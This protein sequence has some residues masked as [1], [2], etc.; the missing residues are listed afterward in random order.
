MSDVVVLASG[1][2]ND[3]IDAGLFRK[4]SIHVFGFLDED[5]DGIQDDNEGRF[6][7]DPGKTFELLDENGD[8]D[9]RQHDH[10]WTARCG[11]TQLMPGTYTVRENP[12]PDGFTLTTL[13]NQRTF[14]VISGVELVYE[15]GAAMLPDGRPADGDEPRATSSAGATPRSASPR[16]TSR[17]SPAWTSIRSTS[18]SWC[19]SRGR[20]SRAT[21]AMCSANR[22]RSP[23]S[24]S[25]PTVTPSIRPRTRTKPRRS[26]TAD[27]D[28]ESYIVVT[29]NGDLFRRGS[30]L[31]GDEFT[32]RWKLWLA[33]RSSRSTMTWPRST[34]GGP[35]LQTFEYHTSCSQPIQ[36]G[37]VIGSVT[38]VGYVGE[39]G[40]AE[41]PDFGPG[42]GDDDADTPTGPTASPGDTV[43]FT[44]VVT[45]P[46]ADTA[47]ANV[48]VTDQVLA[49][50]RGPGIQS[51]PGAG[52]RRI[53]RR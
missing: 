11:S 42:V 45:N 25:R 40:A 15:D 35:L 22:S 21:C 10:G 52:R 32:H 24:T 4:G 36:L 20:R 49:P 41:A 6:P 5:G 19:A 33:I 26:G 51:R 1:E 37:D 43:V 12:I 17:S 28:G 50:S 47:L 34:T 31:E 53:Q 3:T 13:P 44:Y 46:I 7:D 39:D 16:L 14:T 48:V 38:L 2:F 30:V 23:S 8:V 29:M 9:R 18:K 27:L